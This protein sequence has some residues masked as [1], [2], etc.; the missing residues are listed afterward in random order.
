[1]IAPIASGANC[2]MKR[3]VHDLHI[4]SHF[5]S[6]NLSSSL[7]EHSKVNKKGSDSY[8]KPKENCTRITALRPLCIIFCSSN[9][10]FPDV[11]SCCIAEVDGKHSQGKAKEQAGNDAARQVMVR[12]ILSRMGSCLLQWLLRG[13]SG[14]ARPL[15]AMVSTFENNIQCYRINYIVS[16][17]RKN[18]YN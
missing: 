13:H 1:M 10:A 4:F 5:V 18:S 11:F 3:Y 14:D 7:V 6:Y 17:P 16:N 15:R 2:L 9:L 8:Q 12:H